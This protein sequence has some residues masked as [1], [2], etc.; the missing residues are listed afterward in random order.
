M[1]NPKDILTRDGYNLYMAHL[2]NI[3]EAL[4]YIHNHADDLH[5]GAISREEFVMEEGVVVKEVSED[6]IL[7]MYWTFQKIKD[8]LR[9]GDGETE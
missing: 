8:T 2:A 1:Y 5:I 7:D 3:E 4:F 9:N 6:A